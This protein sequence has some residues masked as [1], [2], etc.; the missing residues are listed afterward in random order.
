MGA[1]RTREARVGSADVAIVAAQYPG[2]DARSSGAMHA[3]QTGIAQVAGS[4][5]GSVD[6]PLHGVTAIVSADVV[7]ITVQSQSGHAFATTTKVAGSA[8]IVVGARSQVRSMQAACSTVS[9]I[10]GA[11]VT[12]IAVGRYTGA[13][14]AL[15]A[16]LP[17]GALV[18]IVACKSFVGG[19]HGT[20]A[21][22]RLTVCG[23]A[24]GIYPG[25]LRAKDNR[26]RLHNTEMRQFG[27]IAD[28]GP[29]TSIAIVESLAIGIDEA[30]A[31]HSIAVALPRFA[32]VLHGARVTII[33]RRRVVLRSAATKPVTEVISA[34]IVVIAQ[35]RQTGA[36]TRLTVVT[37]GT[38]ITI[39][40]L[41]AI[42]VD[43]FAAAF[44]TT[45]I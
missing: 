38:G 13:A 42:K 12:V 45:C 35:N 28:K 3:Q 43:M 41:S 17:N 33:T 25:W 30:L 29:V 24:D 11:R 34:G 31:V 44:P 2:E 9:K 27:G 20:D 37:H 5:V 40:T 39:G 21:C 26:G 32:G 6:T 36:V 7:V 16:T 22:P 1:A 15:G 8:G 4:I 23:Q 14:L 19:G 10:I 18:A